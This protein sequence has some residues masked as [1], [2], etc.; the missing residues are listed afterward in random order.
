MLPHPLGLVSTGNVFEDLGFENAEEE[1]LRAELAIA[2]S[3][4][5]HERRWTQREAAE[6]MECSRSDV[7][8]VENMR[9]DGFTI[10][11][12]LR[13]LRMLGKGVTVVLTDMPAHGVSIPDAPAE[14]G[15]APP[16]KRKRGRRPATEAHTEPTT[17]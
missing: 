16:P 15:A 8:A 7:S 2:I 9:L 11:R 13:M 12:L 3:R 6:V 1:K 5:L 17:P 10:D 14:N 4:I